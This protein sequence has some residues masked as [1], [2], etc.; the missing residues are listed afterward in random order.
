MEDIPISEIM[1]S[2]EDLV[3]IRIPG[4]RDVLIETFRKTGLSVY[5]V[6]KKDSDELVGILSRSDLFRNPDE[7]QLSLLMKRDVTTLK[8]ND[9]VIDAARI[10]G[11]NVFQR[12]PIVDKDNKTL[13]GLVARNDVIKKVILKSKIQLDVKSYFNPVPTFLLDHA[14]PPF[15]DF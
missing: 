6:L 5:L 8:P 4:N 15:H 9:L 2:R 14:S 12:I 11:E 7:T 10:Y 3:I 1:T 13:L